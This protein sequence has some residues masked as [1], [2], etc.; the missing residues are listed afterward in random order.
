MDHH[1]DGFDDEQWDEFKWETHL[2]EIE[3]KSEQ[4]RKFIS[5]DHKGNIP[6]WITLL[7]ESKDEDDAFEAYIE[8]ELLMDEAYFPEE[9]DWDD[10]D[11]DWD[12][13]DF[14]FGFSDEDDFMDYEDDFDDFDDL[15][16]G[17]EWKSLSDEY[18]YSDYGDLE[19]LAVY[20]DAKDLAVD[21]LR[22]AEKIHPK[23][24]SKDFQDFVDETLKIGAKIAG[25]HS[26]GFEQDFIGANI[27][28]SK[29]ALYC[30][31]HAL[32]LFSSL[33]K[34]NIFTKR[35]YQEVHA[36]LFELRNDIGIYVQELRD[37][38][39]LGLE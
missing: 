4:L 15:D 6:R 9:E 11:E 33:R 20:L 24:Q 13:D 17:D 34:K 12:E 10:D 25:G 38:F 1:F 22:F 5:S 27:A 3:K 16:A 31:N 21:I 7:K 39:R 32:E 26:F 35:Q 2:N 29:K 19:S 8:E 28:Y 14:L 18:A 37:Q 23:K 36:R 30:A